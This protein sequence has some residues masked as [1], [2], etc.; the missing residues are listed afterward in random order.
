MLI[1][2]IEDI[3]RVFWLLFIPLIFTVLV[4][5]ARHAFYNFSFEYVHK[6]LH[7][8]YRN[9]VNYAAIITVIFSF[10]LVCK[11]MVFF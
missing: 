9:H 8:F 4:T 7:P 6:I 11:T 5:L 10:C 3:K 1:K 2:R